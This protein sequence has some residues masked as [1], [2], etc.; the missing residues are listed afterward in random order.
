MKYFYIETKE[1]ITDKE[2]QKRLNDGFIF[3]C[4]NCH[5]NIGEHLKVV[6]DGIFCSNC[7]DCIMEEIQKEIN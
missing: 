5:K 3:K 6:A 7:F 2:L 4:N 1:W